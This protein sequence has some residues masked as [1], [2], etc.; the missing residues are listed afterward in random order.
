MTGI[1]ARLA[2]ASGAVGIVVLIVGG[3]IFNSDG[4]LAGAG[5]TLPWFSASSRSSSSSP[6]CIGAFGTSRQRAAGWPPWSW[7]RRRVRG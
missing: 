3:E 6:T 4:P 7:A 2:A 1:S 5:Y